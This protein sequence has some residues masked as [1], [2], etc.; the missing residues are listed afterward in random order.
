MHRVRGAG[1]LP[2][3]VGTLL[4]EP[5]YRRLGERYPRWLLADAI[6]EQLAEERSAG[7]V[8]GG[9]RLERVASR[10]AGW[11]A[12]R[13]RPVINGTGVVLHTNLGRAPISHAAAAAAAGIAT[14][15]SNLE[16]DLESG[17]RG[18]RHALVAPLLTRL[19]G[20]EAA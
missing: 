4:N 11:T 15:Y 10:L 8:G 19:T 18:D 13:L 9:E 2:P 5:G 17:R 7:T 16:L 20:A 3:A 6:R 12:P 1:P 14:G